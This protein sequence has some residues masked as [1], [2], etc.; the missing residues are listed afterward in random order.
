MRAILSR[1]YKSRILLGGYIYD[2]LHCNQ[3][4]HDSFFW[5][6]FDLFQIRS[7]DWQR[8]LEKQKISLEFEPRFPI[9]QRRANLVVAL[10][11]TMYQ[12]AHQSDLGKT[13]SKGREFRDLGANRLTEEDFCFSEKGRINCLQFIG[14]RSKRNSD[15]IGSV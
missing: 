4:L 1:L 7:F 11:L 10:P 2:L 3:N 14:R 12:R 13:W 15:D 8:F 6:H 9:Q 5:V